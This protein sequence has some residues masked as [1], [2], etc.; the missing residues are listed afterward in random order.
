MNRTCTVVLDYDIE[1]ELRLAGKGKPMIGHK[2]YTFAGHTLMA[3]WATSKTGRKELMG[4]KEFYVK[5][6]KECHSTD[7][8]YDIE[9]FATCESAK[10]DNLLELEALAGDAAEQTKDYIYVTQGSAD[11]VK[12]LSEDQRV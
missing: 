1:K 8:D 2:E 11:P 6:W 12:K 3:K 5:M 9:F 10:K 7:Y 4:C